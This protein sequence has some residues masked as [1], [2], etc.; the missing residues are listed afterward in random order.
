MKK[1]TDAMAVTR[2][3]LKVVKTGFGAIL[4]SAVVGIAGLAHGTV[5][6]FSA[7]D[8]RNP[9]SAVTDIFNKGNM[10]NK[11]NTNIVRNQRTS[12]NFVVL[13]VII[14]TNKSFSKYQKYSYI[15]MGSVNY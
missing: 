7:G 3:T 15:N 11:T 10:I 1:H 2:K 14:R 8:M 12:E 13:D 5:K 4:G 6:G 9:A